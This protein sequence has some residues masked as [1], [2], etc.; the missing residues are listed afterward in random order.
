[1]PM[2]MQVVSSAA[3][4]IRTG[5]RS[6]LRRSEIGAWPGSHQVKPEFTTGE[7]D[8]S[9]AWDASRIAGAHAQWIDR[10]DPFMRYLRT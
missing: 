7:T 3:D 5:K 8:I 2:L 9:M 6:D 4:R 1:M 10:H